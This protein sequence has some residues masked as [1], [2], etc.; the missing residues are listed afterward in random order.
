MEAALEYK[1]TPQTD[2]NLRRQISVFVTVGSPG[3]VLQNL[4][5]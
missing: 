4:Q 1:G 5:E 3:S 2:E